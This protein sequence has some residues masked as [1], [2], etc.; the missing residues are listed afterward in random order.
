MLK[1][2]TTVLVIG[3]SGFL[4]SHVVDTLIKKNYKVIVY[5]KIKSKWLNKKQKYVKGSLENYRLVEKQIKKSQYVYNF[6]GIGD[7][8]YGSNNPLKTIKSNIYLNSLICEFCI[9]YKI[10][11][12]IYSSSVYVYSDKGSFYK[13]SKQAAESYIEEYSK[14]YN[15]KYTILRFGSLYGP[16]S[17]P[18]N[19]LYKVIW[20]YFK[21]GNIEYSGSK[22]TLR[23]YIHIKDAAISCVDILKKK[24]ENKHVVLSGYKKFLVKNILESL[25]KTLNFKGNIKY[26]NTKNINHY[27]ISPYTFQPNFGIRYYNKNMKSIKKEIINLVK[28]VKAEIK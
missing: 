24:F 8:D 3:G 16:R 13:S 26:N 11:R 22:K 25:S 19:G 6:A 10:K 2:K 1:K 18:N 9:K 15:L 27:D 21:S 17:S 12:F 23:E 20:N 7:L 4:G 5:D 14:K 28:Y